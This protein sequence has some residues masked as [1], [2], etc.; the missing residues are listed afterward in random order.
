MT[1]GNATPMIVIAIFG[2]AP[3]RY[4]KTTNASPPTTTHRPPSMP[5]AMRLLTS[6][7]SR[8]CEYQPPESTAATATTSERPQRPP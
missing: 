4:G 8:R 5:R 3:G 6:R 7:A 1:E 2:A